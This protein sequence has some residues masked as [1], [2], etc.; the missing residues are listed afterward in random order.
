M[1]KNLWVAHMSADIIWIIARSYC[2]S[3]LAQLIGTVGNHMYLV[4]I[5][6]R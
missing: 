3:L 6:S 4:L 1:L 5:A 2:N